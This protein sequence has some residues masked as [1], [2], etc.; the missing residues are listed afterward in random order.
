MKY[1]NTPSVGV[2]VVTFN[3][4][5]YLRNL[6]KSLSKIDYPISELLIF[7]N[8]SDYSI[9]HLNFIKEISFSGNPKISIKRSKIKIGRAHV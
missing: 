7:D 6:I 9:E 2:L 3:R 1:S 8:N 5:E 4:I